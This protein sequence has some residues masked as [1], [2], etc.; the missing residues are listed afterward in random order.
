MLERI[1]LQPGGNKVGDEA[2]LIAIAHIE[3]FSKEPLPLS[4]SLA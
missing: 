3:H 1:F 4:V 2:Q